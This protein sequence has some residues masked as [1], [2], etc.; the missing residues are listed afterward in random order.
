MR[1]RQ[2]G[3][4]KYLLSARQRWAISR[5]QGL[6]ETALLFPV[7]L[8]VLS[9]LIEFGFGLNEYLAIQDAARNAA[10]WESDGLYYRT[11]SN[12]SCDP[13][14][15]TED[16][17]RQAACVVYQELSQERPEVTLDFTNDHDDVVVS[18]FSIAQEYCVPGF[19]DPPVPR[20]DPSP[21]VSCVTRRHPPAYGDAGWSASLDQTGARNQSSRISSAFVNERLDNMAPSTGL[22]VVE[23]FHNYE[24]K[25]NLPWI[26]VFITD[27]LTLHNYA[28]MPLVSAEPTPTPPSP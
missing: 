7:L 23:V 13:V 12:H 27:T 10:R 8:V 15:G 3:L 24:Q 26:T 11:D 22:V 19:V 1:I 20:I 17:Y 4:K 28:I 14:S 9:S 21:G 16:F 2:A 25:L 6:V 18:A 5:G